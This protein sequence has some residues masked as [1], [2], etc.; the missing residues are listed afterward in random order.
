MLCVASKRKNP[1]GRG[2]ETKYKCKQCD[3]PLCVWG[4]FFGIPPEAKC[5]GAKLVELVL[6]CIN[7]LRIR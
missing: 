2:K 1:P 5:G 4:V 6:T 7:L 3:F